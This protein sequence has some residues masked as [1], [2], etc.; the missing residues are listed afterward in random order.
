MG[1]IDFFGEVTPRHVHQSA[2][3]CA[4][5]DQ[6]RTH[7]TLRGRGDPPPIAS[8]SPRRV[9]DG[10]AFPCPSPTGEG[11]WL[12][13]PLPPFPPSS[14]ADV[15]EG[16]EFRKRS[17]LMLME[18]DDSV[19]DGKHTECARV[20]GGGEGGRGRGREGGRRAPVHPGR[21]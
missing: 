19:S 16:L 2:S 14:Q 4:S 1:F 5:L 17:R 12:V 20:P 10:P 11:W 8:R 3:G 13:P 21:R 18:D 7:S 9:D 6:A 15:P